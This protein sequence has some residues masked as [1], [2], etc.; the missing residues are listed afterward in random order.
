LA[1]KEP[2]GIILMPGHGKVRTNVLNL[3]DLTPNC[4]GTLQSP[5]DLPDI[6]MVTN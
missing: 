5:I 6:V 1:R 4:E 2:N 3:L